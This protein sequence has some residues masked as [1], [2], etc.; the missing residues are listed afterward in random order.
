MRKT[1]W[2]VLVALALFLPGVASAQVAWDSPM[3]LPPGS[4]PGFGLY[5]IDVHFG[6]I[7]V[8]GTWRSPSWNFGLRGGIAEDIRRRGDD[9]SGVAIFAG[10]DFDGRLTR[11]SDE[12]PLDMDWVL[13]AGLSVGDDVWIA[14]PLGL[15]LGHTFR[16]EGVDFTPYATPRVVLDAILGENGRGDDDDVSLDFAFD[17]GL[18]L[19]FSRNFTVRFGA[20]LGDREAVAIGVVF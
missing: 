18:D 8:L 17:L 4:Q 12:F 11:S 14:V 1:M 6:E 3:L 15:S 9:D 19:R 5:L 20:T 7:G 2:G 16:G 10:I 13:G